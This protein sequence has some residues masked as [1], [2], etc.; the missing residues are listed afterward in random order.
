MF[1]YEFRGR[2]VVSTGSTTRMGGHSNVRLRP[3]MLESDPFTGDL[4]HGR[5]AIS[6]EITVAPPAGLEPATT[7]LEVRRSI[8]LSY[9]GRAHATRSSATRSRRAPE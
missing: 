8:Q 1:D 9:E 3:Q 6:R 4:Q 2:R 7:G 5:V